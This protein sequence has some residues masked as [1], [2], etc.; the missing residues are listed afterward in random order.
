MEHI[1]FL[2]SPHNAR[3]HT[4]TQTHSWTVWQTLF[5]INYSL[6]YPCS[7]IILYT[8]III[9]LLTNESHYSSMLMDINIQLLLC[10]SY[11]LLFLFALVTFLPLPI[12]ISFLFFILLFLFLPFNDLPLHTWN[13]SSFLHVIILLLFCFLFYLSCLEQWAYTYICKYVTLAFTE[14]FA[15]VC[16][17]VETYYYELGFHYFPSYYVFSHVYKR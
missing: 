9:P 5:Q 14:L 3:I 6:A 7:F 16:L 15:N 10:A 12:H 1:S 11:S 13:I 4:Q 2:L 8:Y 17:R